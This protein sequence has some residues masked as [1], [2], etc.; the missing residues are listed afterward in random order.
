MSVETMDASKARKE[1]VVRSARAVKAARNEGSCGMGARGWMYVKKSST[2]FS[3]MGS[4]HMSSAVRERGV[5]R[6]LRM[7]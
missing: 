6:V 5:L 7:L 1:G 3:S 4:G 2:S